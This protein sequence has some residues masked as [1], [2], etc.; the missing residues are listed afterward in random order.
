MHLPPYS[1]T[2]DFR[3][4][5]QIA[6]AC[7]VLAKMRGEQLSAAK[8]IVDD[9]TKR[10]FLRKRKHP[11]ELSDA[12]IDPATVPWLFLDT[13]EEIYEPGEEDLLP[14]YRARLAK[15]LEDQQKT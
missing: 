15:F 10:A 11:S 9:M 8:A 5:K 1:V 14:A 4:I 12:E 3:E 7:G 6:Q 13:L 2:L